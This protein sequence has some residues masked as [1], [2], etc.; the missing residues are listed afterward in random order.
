MVASGGVSVSSA[1]PST[2]PVEQEVGV[3]GLYHFVQPFR[4]DGRVF[5]GFV[6]FSFVAVAQDWTDIEPHKDGESAGSHKQGESWWIVLLLGQDVCKYLRQG[7]LLTNVPI[8]GFYL[9]EDPL[10]IYRGVDFDEFR[11]SKQGGADVFEEVTHG[12]E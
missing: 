4:V 7:Y 11:F 1:R 8:E 12:R 6:G 9:H 3:A 5:I 10:A 2:H